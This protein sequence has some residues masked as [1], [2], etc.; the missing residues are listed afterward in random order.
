VLEKSDFELDSLLRTFVHKQFTSY[1][2]QK[3]HDNSLS[4]VFCHNLLIF[5]NFRVDFGFFQIGV[6]L[7]ADLTSYAPVLCQISC[8]CVPIVDTN[9]FYYYCA[10]LEFFRSCLREKSSILAVS[11]FLSSFNSLVWCKFHG[12]ASFTDLI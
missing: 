7:A 9:S 10:R 8:S 11:V 2:G 1:S 4:I 6:D 5:A 12:A 3:F